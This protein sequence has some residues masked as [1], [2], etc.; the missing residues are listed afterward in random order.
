M[1]PRREGTCGFFVHHSSG[2]VQGAR[3]ADC[4]SLS[5]AAT[6]EATTPTPDVLFSNKLI[7]FTLAALI[8][9]TLAA[10]I[11]L[12]ISSEN[13]FFSLSISLSGS[14]FRSFA[15]YAFPNSAIDGLVGMPR[16]SWSGFLQ[17]P[18]TKSAIPV[19]PGTSSG[20]V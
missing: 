20:D 11:R 4:N 8:I 6:E 10:L 2:T 13:F 18:R 17:M 15:R 3:G 5:A 9:F 14:C 19:A 12:V 1:N 7:I 16:I